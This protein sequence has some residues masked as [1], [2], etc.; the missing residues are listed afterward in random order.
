MIKNKIN[1]NFY[2][3]R[4]KWFK[5]GNDVNNKNKYDSWYNINDKRPLMN[6]NYNLSN[7]LFID[8]SSNNMQL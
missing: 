4:K 5:A 6:T 8:T 7:R 1:N 2:D 3:N